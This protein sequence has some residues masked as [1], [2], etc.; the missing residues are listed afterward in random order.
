MMRTLLVRG[1]LAGLIAGVLATLFAYFFGEPSV[2]VAIGLEEAGQHA[3]GHA[4][5]HGGH[6]HG[7]DAL[8][9]RDVQST[10]GLFT[11]VALYGVAIGG[12]FAIAFAVLHGRIGNLRPRLTASLLAAGAFVVVVLV[13]FLKYPANPPAVGQPG[14]IGDRTS[15]YFGFLALSLVLAGAALAGGRLL[16]ARLGAWSAGWLAA[17]GYVVAVAVTAWLLPVIDE[18]PEGF[19]GST[20][21]TFRLASLGTHVVL[22]TALGLTFG[23]LVERSGR[24]GALSPSSR[25]FVPLE[26][27]VSGRRAP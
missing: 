26:S 7:D 2:R 22:W 25:G 15:L 20:L 23:A 17:G 19:P 4:H 13:P 24:V 27:G 5:D 6:G 3:H 21:W 8:V 12:L 18:V 11:G 14:T 9:S 1:M 16:V 10:F